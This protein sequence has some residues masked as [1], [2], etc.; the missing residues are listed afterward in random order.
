MGLHHIPHT[1]DLPVTTTPG[2]DLN[3]YLLPYNYF[4]ECPAMRSRDAIRIEPEV[5]RSPD[6]GLKVELRKRN[7][8]FS[9]AARN[10]SN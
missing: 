6:Y 7:A 10:I 9:S 5:K 8:E 1:E 4:P 3:F 2:L